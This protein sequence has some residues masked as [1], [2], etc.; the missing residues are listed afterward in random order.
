[1]R[2]QADNYFRKK[3]AYGCLTGFLMHVWWFSLVVYCYSKFVFRTDNLQCLRKKTPN[4]C[5]LGNLICLEHLRKFHHIWF[6][7][8]FP[9]ERKKEKFISKNSYFS[10]IFSHL[11]RNYQEMEM[12][13]VQLIR[14]DRLTCFSSKLDQETAFSCPTFTWALHNYIINFSRK[15]VFWRH[16]EKYINY[17]MPIC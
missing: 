17:I 1:M 5:F 4:K 15:N 2:L 12:A 10:I 3:S 13:K 6:S 11:P 14:Q 16:G 8:L 9:K 7:K